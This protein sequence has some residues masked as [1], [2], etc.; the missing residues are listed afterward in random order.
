MHLNKLA[1]APTVNVE[2]YYK[3]K[4]EKKHN[5]IYSRTP[6]YIFPTARSLENTQHH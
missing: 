5:S 6:I 3:Q 4:R 1:P 2:T